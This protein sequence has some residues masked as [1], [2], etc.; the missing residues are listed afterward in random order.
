MALEYQM[1]I[2]GLGSGSN[3]LAALTSKL[4]EVIFSK[5]AVGIILFWY[6]DVHG[7]S[8]RYLMYEVS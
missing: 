4:D 6:M 8:T 7:R 1:Q 3:D 5:E 2:R